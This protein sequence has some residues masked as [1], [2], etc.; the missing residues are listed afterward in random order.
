MN[1]KHKCSLDWLQERQRYLTASDIKKLLPVTKTGRPRKVDELDYVSVMASKMTELTEE[2]CWSYGVMARGHLLEPYAVAAL[3]QALLENNESDL[4]FHW[5]DK[6][7][8]VPGREIAFSPDAMDVGMENS[9]P[10]KNVTAIAEIKSYS[11]DRHL[12]CGYTPKMQLEERWQIATA[13]ALLNNIDHAWLVFYNPK[14]KFRKL[15]VIR[16]DRDDLVEEIDKVLE[17][18]RAWHDFKLNGVLNDSPADGFW[19]AHGC[20]EASIVDAIEKAE[21]LNP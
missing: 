12:A 2:D 18:E 21:R 7:V 20:S 11:P 16:Y 14:M 10:A 1:W 19:T 17:V 8:S 6:L 4:L 15:I 13:M 3:N 5:D 9:D